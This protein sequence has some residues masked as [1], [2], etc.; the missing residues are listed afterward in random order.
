LSR[1]TI[2]DELGID[3]SGDVIT[4]TV[5]YVDHDSVRARHVGDDYVA[6]SL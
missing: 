2:G 5:G 6:T 4:P 3:P 1:S